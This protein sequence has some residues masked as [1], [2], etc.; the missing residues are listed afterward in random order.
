[1]LSFSKF[2]T[3]L[4]A[5]PLLISTL[6][7]LVAIYDAGFFHQPDWYAL[8]NG[9][10]AFN[11]VTGALM[12]ATRLVRPRLAPNWK[13]LLA[14]A[15]LF[16]GIAVILTA[17]FRPGAGGMLF[18]QG[19]GFWLRLASI[20]VFIREVS[21]NSFKLKRTA[22]HPAQ[23]F[24][25]SFVVV[26]ITGSLMLSLPTAH[27]ERISFIQ[28]LFTSASA[29]CVTGL[30]VVDTGTFFTLFGQSIILSLIQIGGLGIMTFASYFSYFFMGGSSFSNQ[31]ILSEM[32]HNEKLSRVFSTLKNVLLVTLS[33]ETAGAL[34]I[35]Q[36]LEPSIIPNISDRVFFSVFHSISAFCNAGFSTLP[37]GMYELPFQ[38]NYPLH[39]II[40]VLIILGGLGFPILSNLW[41]AIN[42]WM[43]AQIKRLFNKAAPTS[44]PRF[45]SLN[46]KLILITTLALNGIGTLVFLV[47]EHDG[48]LSGHGIAGKIS[49]AFFT[50]VTARTAGFSTLDVA[51]LSLPSTLFLMVLMWIGASPASTGGGIKTSTF[52]LALM[53]TVR[54]IRGADRLELFGRQISLV[55]INRS[56]AIVVLSLA[57]IMISVSGLVLTD[58]EK[59]LL[60]IVFEC[61]SAYCT[62]GLSRGITAGLSAPGQFILV[63]TMIAGR[64]GMFSLLV[65]LTTQIRHTRYRFP[66][67]EILIN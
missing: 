19:P 4:K 3:R 40:A 5:V 67:E 29:V 27:V 65:S 38:L 34:F 58:P 21:A 59:G 50:A 43:A 48:T 54:S 44:V 60:N 41:N 62:V 2:A 24:V 16:A 51:A 42:M 7:L 55:S 11:L 25:L 9:W 57:A 17:C 30:I 8:F 37:N 22:V 20:L 35:Y 26:I 10:Y 56:Y 1:V 53:N 32:T 15:A 23:L 39:V 49:G 33:F 46:A 6:T 31:M 63:L 66:S 14:D 12:L 47:A 45:I 28:A 52:A 61:V 18:G 13:V 64:V 36:T